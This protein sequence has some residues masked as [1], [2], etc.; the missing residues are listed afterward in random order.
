M[1]F[2][3]TLARRLY[4]KH[5]DHRFML[6]A[7]YGGSTKCFAMVVLE[8]PSISFTQQCWPSRRIT[9]ASEAIAIHRQMFLN[10]VNANSR[11]RNVFKELITKLRKQSYPDLCE[12]DVLNTTNAFFK[13]LYVTD[14]W[15]CGN[16]SVQKLSKIHRQQ[17]QDDWYAIV[18]EEFEA[19]NPKYVILAGEHAK[20]CGKRFATSVPPLPIPFPSWRNPDSADRLSKLL[21]KLP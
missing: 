2:F 10:W 21:A 7:L 8:A 3:E 9:S 17:T 11:Q 19:I 14:V 20:R 4:E 13:F 6:P 12:F 18:Q 1:S 16:P 15:K 5:P